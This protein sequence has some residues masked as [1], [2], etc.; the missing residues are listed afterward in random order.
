MTDATHRPHFNLIEEPWISCILEGGEV[1]DLGLRETLVRAHEVRDITDPSPLVQAG[2]FRMLLAVCHR[3]VDGPATVDAWGGVWTAGHFSAAEVDAYLYG[4][5]CKGRFDLFDAERPFYQTAAVG[6]SYAGPVALLAIERASGNNATLFDHSY[7]RDGSALTPARAARLLLAHHAFALGGTG[8]HEQGRPQ[9]KY[10][11]ASPLVNGAVGVV[12]GRNLFCTLL[13]NL[14]QYDGA[15]E[16]PF[17]FDPTVDAPAWEQDT[18]AM[19]EARHPRGHLDVLTWQSRRLRLRAEP[20]SA[21]GTL[22]TGAVVMNGRQFPESVLRADFETMVAFRAREKAKPGE[23]PYM[24]V[25]F[26]EDRS[27]WRNALALVAATQRYR[28]PR[29]LDWLDRLQ[30]ARVLAKSSVYPLD[31]FGL[32]ADKAKPLLWRHE[33]LPLPLVYLDPE[34][35]DAVDALGNALQLAES[36]ERVLVYVTRDMACLLLAPNSDHP[37]GRKPDSA[38]VDELARSMNAVGLYW[39]RL[40][41]PFRDLVVA[42]PT[43]V[44]IDAG[45]PVYGAKEVPKWLDALR[46]AA[47]EAFDVTRRGV[48][49]NGARGLK[50]GAVSSHTFESRLA[51]ALNPNIRP[52]GSNP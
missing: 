27:M 46:N 10:M 4:E 49:S 50:A 7:D 12:K 51:G 14:Q 21:G 45:V 15:A 5:R 44:E 39:A 22:V 18:P 6:L 32:T 47:R 35:S 41:A 9:D 30:K 42:L 25:G 8:S 23:D 17:P 28:R 19:V 13:L 26:R 16:Y 37:D 36:V 34:N 31:L 43:D 29:S 11:R 48:Q 3:V 1:R 2:L 38:A 20:D 52:G 40:D 24:I 33:R